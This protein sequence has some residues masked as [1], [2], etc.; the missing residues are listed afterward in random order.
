MVQV[1]S[2]IST[3]TSPDCSAVKRLVEVSGTYFT[4]DVSAKIA[5]ARARQPSASRPFITPW[6]S[7]SEKPGVD[8]STPQTSCPRALI[9]SSVAEPL[10]SA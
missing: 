8:P 6:L 7:G 5:A 9:A 2:R 3:S 1:V 4:L 10:P